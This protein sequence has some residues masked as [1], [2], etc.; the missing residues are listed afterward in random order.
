M[1]FSSC[2]KWGWVLLCSILASSA[3]GAGTAPTKRF[4]QSVVQGTIQSKILPAVVDRT[5]VNV[6]VILPGASVADEQAA[7]GRRLTRQEKDG[8]KAQRAVEQAAKR[9]QI[10]GVGGQVIGT[11]QS[12]LNGV[13]VRIPR[14]QVDALRQIPGV[15]DV[16]RVGLHKLVN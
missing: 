9:S 10:E 14:N 16:V 11:F 6:V 2:K 13:K 1:K 12:A 7:A 3:I 5:P 8:V 15:V 4:R